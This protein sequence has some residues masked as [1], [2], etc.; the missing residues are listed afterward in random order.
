MPLAYRGYYDIPFVILGHTMTCLGHPGAHYDNDM[1][2]ASSS[3]SF[4]NG[5][6]AQKLMDLELARK[7]SHPP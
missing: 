6:V 2:L 3:P 4:T 7:V 1:P 5:L